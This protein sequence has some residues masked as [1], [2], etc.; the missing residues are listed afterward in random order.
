MDSHRH[1]ELK[2][3]LLEREIEAA[4]DVD[5]SPEF[6]ARVRTRVARERVNDGWVGLGVWRWAGAVAVVTAVAIV[7]LLTMRDP[8]P[9]PREVHISTPVA[10]PMRRAPDPPSVQNETP[11]TLVASAE[12]PTPE[13]RPIARTVPVPL[14]PA[15]AVQD[16]IVVSGDE[17]VALRQLVVAIVARQVKAVDIPE[18]GVETAPLPAIEEIVLEPITLSPMDGALE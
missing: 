16:G 8:W 12:S 4:L 5:P 17:V 3:E 11:P 6:L 14:R 13:R 1:E 18:L 10:E 15:G 2:D 9:E 7:G